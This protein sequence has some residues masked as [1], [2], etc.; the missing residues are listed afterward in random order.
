VTCVEIATDRTLSV[1]LQDPCKL[2]SVNSVLV[3]SGWAQATGVGLAMHTVTSPH[4]C[5][6]IHCVRWKTDPLDIVQ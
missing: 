3:S 1:F 6:N 4:L 2:Q 5:C